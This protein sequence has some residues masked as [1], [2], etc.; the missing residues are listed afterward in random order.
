[1]NPR[2]RRGVTIAS[3]AFALVL[4]SA[5]AAWLAFDGGD[6]DMAAAE[7]T[8]TL[9]RAGTTLPTT[10]TVAPT[11]TTSPQIGPGD[12]VGEYR[13]KLIRKD[14]PGTPDTF[15]VVSVTLSQEGDDLAATITHGPVGANSL[16]RFGNVVMPL[17]ATL[18]D[19]HLTLRWDES[20]GSFTDT[21]FTMCAWEAW[22]MNLVVE[23]GGE[24]L[25]LIDGFVRGELPENTDVSE[26]YIG[27]PAGER[28]MVRMT[29]VRQ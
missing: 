3:I 28:P 7:S 29:L 19:E 25:V 11:S 10:T 23:E 14:E 20:T 9:D 18:D 16:D 4:V 8:T 13:G 5:L 1:M 6:D 21:T 2:T 26:W 27:C 24:R 17:E 22:L 15:H 12:L